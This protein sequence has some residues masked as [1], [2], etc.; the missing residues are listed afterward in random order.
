MVR[1]KTPTS[2][3]IGGGALLLLCI[4]YNLAP[5]RHVNKASLDEVQDPLFTS[6][7]RQDDNDEADASETQEE[8]VLFNTLEHIRDRK[9]NSET[10]DITY[11]NNE[12]DNN[13]KTSL[14]NAQ[15]GS[16]DTETKIDL[17]NIK[18]PGT[19]GFQKDNIARE[20]QEE[21]GET[22]HKA[23]DE[24]K[25]VNDDNDETK[26][27]TLVSMQDNLLETV[28]SEQGTGLDE[29]DNEDTYDK[30]TEHY[31]IESEQSIEK[32][33]GN[34]ANETYLPKTKKFPGLIIIGIHKCGT[35]ALSFFL[36]IHPN[37][38]RT[39][40]QEIHFFD[41]V[42][43]YKKGL[44]YYI[45][46]MPLT[47]PTQIGYEKTPGYFD[48]ANPRDIYNANKDVKLAI[49]VC[50]PV[51][52]TMSNH[53]LKTLVFKKNVTYEGCILHE[54]GTLNTEGCPYI[55]RGHYATYFKRYLEV[56]PRE[57]I[58]VVSTD[59]LKTDPISVIKKFEIFLNLPKVVNDNMLYLD[60]TT[61]QFCV[62][63]QYWSTKYMGKYNGCMLRPDKH[64]VHP[65]IHPELIKKL[66]NHFR[67]QNREFVQMTG[68]NFSWVD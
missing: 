68:K 64:Q 21:S 20:T 8:D 24:N 38:V 63:P 50:D 33:T 35:F 36:Q 43:E 32:K 23:I 14:G 10:K 1:R 65:E 53:L 31:V 12:N 11:G 52:R 17:S 22:N 25:S 46:Q 30:E 40:G 58:L 28:K 49:I 7:K 56:F 62:K 3:I 61:K 39:Q 41:W 9:Q 48:G 15:T 27:T 16:D 19:N 51:R 47:D 29:N 2:F 66:T 67:D 13:M 60:E 5:L 44:D 59:E 54:N 18:P 4:T 45:S 26:K 37:L 6:D 55:Y 34:N 42:M 57:Q